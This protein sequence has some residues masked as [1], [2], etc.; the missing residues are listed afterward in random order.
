MEQRCSPADEQTTPSG[1]ELPALVITLL[2]G[3]LLQ[4]GGG[5]LWVD[6]LRHQA[7]VRDY[8]GTLGLE[9]YLDEIEGYAF[10]RSKTITGPDSNAPELPRLMKRHQL[11]F[12]VSLLLALLRKKLAEL[13]TAGG[14]TRLVLTLDEIV[15]LVRV[16]LPS[17]T[18]EAKFVNKIEQHLSKIVELGLIRE[19]KSQFNAQKTYEVLRLIKAFVDAQWLNEFETRLETYRRHSKYSA[20]NSNDD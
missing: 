9:L 16:F 4:D 10:L 18:N 17:G 7:A 14:A 15:E 1:N 6:L 8:V 5:T 13:D 20:G 11:S 19:L 3:V 12:P 2:K